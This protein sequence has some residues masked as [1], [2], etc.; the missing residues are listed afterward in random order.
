M[1]GCSDSVASGPKAAWGDAPGAW[2]RCP[3]RTA[4]SH[5]PTLCTVHGSERRVSLRPE[6]ARPFG[7]EVRRAGPRCSAPSPSPLPS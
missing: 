2:R 3:P 1:P 7:A 4:P 6:V 5:S